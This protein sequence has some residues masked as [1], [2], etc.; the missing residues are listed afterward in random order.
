MRQTFQWT[1]CRSVRTC[2]GRSVCPVH[3]GKTAGSGMSQVVGFGDWSTG[4]GTFG[5]EFGARHCN[6]WGLFGVECYSA[7]TRPSSQIAL[8]RL[9]DVIDIQCVYSLIA[10]VKSDSTLM[11][12]FVDLAKYS[13][14]W[15]LQ[16][17]L[18]PPRL[19]RVFFTYLTS[20]YMS[21]FN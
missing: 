16:W 2:V 1:V 3:C 9:V 5:G 17:K 19:R 4:R 7:A 15:R 21:V 14:Q 20:V 18:Q 8:G 12:D 10:R 11:A 13:R 6:Q